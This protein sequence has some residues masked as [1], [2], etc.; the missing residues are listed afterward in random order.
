MLIGRNADGINVGI[1]IRQSTPTQRRQNGEGQARCSGAVWSQ[2]CEPGLSLFQS[3]VTR[4][5]R[6]AAE[7]SDV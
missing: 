4:R 2:V 3:G 5:A 7:S 6:T 1:A